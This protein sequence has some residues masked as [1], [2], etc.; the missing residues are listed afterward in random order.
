MA[1]VNP[2]PGLRA[3]TSSGYRPRTDVC[4]PSSI[5]GFCWCDKLHVSLEVI[6]EEVT[7]G[8]RLGIIR[9]VEKPMQNLTPVF[10]TCVEVCAL[11]NVLKVGF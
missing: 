9:V 6:G 1:P 3:L 5:A 4:H 8:D 10:I 11:A 2:V 7:R